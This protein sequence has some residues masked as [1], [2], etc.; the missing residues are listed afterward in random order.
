MSIYTVKNTYHI[1]DYYKNLIQKHP[2]QYGHQFIIE[3]IAPIGQTGSILEGDNA[4]GRKDHSDIECFT[5]WAQSAEIPELT[6]KQGTVTFLANDFIV[7]GVIQ[8]KD[9][10]TTEILLDQ[11]LTQYNK[12]QAWHRLISDFSKSGGGKKVIP[13]VQAK[14]SLLDNTMQNVKNTFIMEGVWLSS[15]DAIDF[16]YEVGGTTI[17]KCKAKFVYQYFYKADDVSAP[18]DSD[19]L[20]P[21]VVDT[22][23]NISKLFIN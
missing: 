22:I 8:Y 10:W 23:A 18:T 12:L 15:L 17:Q 7:P 6:V 20:S 11:D 13:N 19:P 16:G 9:S 14:V 5:Y 21:N 1:A 4:F 2:M 3:F